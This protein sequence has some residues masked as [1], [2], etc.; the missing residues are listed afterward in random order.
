MPNHHPR[1][2]QGLALF[3][4]SRE[5]TVPPRFEP[6]MQDGRPVNLQISVKSGISALLNL[7][8]GIQNRRHRGLVQASER[9]EHVRRFLR[10]VHPSHF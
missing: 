3:Y 1:V 6:A 2:R 8:F 5:R 4:A 7:K 9:P 10:T